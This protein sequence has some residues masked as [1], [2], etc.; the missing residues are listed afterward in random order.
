MTFIVELK[1][2]VYTFRWNKEGSLKLWR[3]N[4]YEIVA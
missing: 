1:H 4:Y 2:D 3:N